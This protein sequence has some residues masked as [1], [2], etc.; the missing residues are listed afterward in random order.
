MTNIK[1]IIYGNSPIDIIELFYLIKEMPRKK[2]KFAQKEFK[3]Y[4]LI[5]Y[6]RLCEQSKSMK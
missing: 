4:A 3:K 5:G 6:E 1:R 2:K